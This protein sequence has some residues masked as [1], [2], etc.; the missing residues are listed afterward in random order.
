MDVNQSS[1]DPPTLA[2]NACSS[3]INIAGTHKEQF[4]TNHTPCTTSPSSHPPPT[5]LAHSSAT[6]VAAP[7]AA[8]PS[9]SVAPCVTLISISNALP[10]L[11]I[12][13]VK[14]IFMAFALAMNRL[15]DEVTAENREDPVLNAQTELQRLQLEL[16]MA[17]ELAKMMASFNLSSL[18]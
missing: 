3:S 16:Q 18:V 9:P 15:S 11:K 6:P 14:R 5:P 4:N 8:I 2:F 1:Q 17:Q 12:L 10:C 13:Q 7:A